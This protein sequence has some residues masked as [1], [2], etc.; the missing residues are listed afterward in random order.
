MEAIS[1]SI[2][3]CLLLSISIV[4]ALSKVY[5]FF[6]DETCCDMIY[7]SFLFSGKTKLVRRRT[8]E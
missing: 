3:F 5:L 8:K 2:Q 4:E 7:M 1:F 6:V